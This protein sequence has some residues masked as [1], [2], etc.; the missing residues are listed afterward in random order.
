MANRKTVVYTEPSDVAKSDKILASSTGYLLSVLLVTMNER[1]SVNLIKSNPDN[2]DAPIHQLNGIADAAKQ[3][4]MNNTRAAIAVDVPVYASYINTIIKYTNEMINTCGG[5][6]A[7][8]STVV[9]T[10][11]YNS[12]ILQSVTEASVPDQQQVDP[13]TGVGIVDGAGHPVMIAGFKNPVPVLGTDGLPKYYTV[14]HLQIYQE[15]PPPSNV[16]VTSAE[17]LCGNVSITCPNRVI[18][19]GW[20]DTSSAD[21]PG[22]VNICSNINRPTIVYV[23]GGV[24]ADPMPYVNR[25]DIIYANTF[26]ALSLNLRLVS[27][28][29]DSYNDWWDIN[30][31]CARLC[32]VACQRACMLSCQSCY[33][34]TCHNQNCGG[35][36]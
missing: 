10:Y 1:D 27:A 22:F 14:T 12:T 28:A 34:G 20:K 16:D 33:G 9:C 21:D 17:R 6:V 32:Q 26:A 13:V 4:E 11:P 25:G 29:L 19:Y 2:F 8:L 18:R 24:A 23:A 15:G 7:Q 5:A 3:T 31:V 35:W 36:S 30:G